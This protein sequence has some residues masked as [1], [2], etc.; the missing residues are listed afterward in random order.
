M[1]WLLF[2]DESGHDHRNTP[3]E[4]HGGFAIHASRLWQFISA[5]RT[6]EQ[7]IFGADLREYGLEL[8][9]SK[10]LKAR[11][12]EWQ[13]QGPRMDEAARRKHAL[14]FLNSGKQR[15]NPRSEEFAAY[16]QGCVAMA[17]G[18]IRLL[19]SHDARL[20]ASIVPRHAKPADAQ[21]DVLRKDIVFLLERFFYFLEGQRQ[22]GLLV[23]DGT[24]K[25]ADRQVVR[26]MERY[27]PNTLTDR[28][29]TQWIVPVPLF[30]E[31]DMAYG[32]Q[33]ADLCIYC[34]TWGWRLRGRMTEPTRPEIE[35]FAEL[36]HRMQWR[37]DGYRAGTVFHTHGFCYVP[38]LYDT[39]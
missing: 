35:P 15:R 18:T 9:G 22:M 29:R 23:M 14:N 37:G 34:L 2:L 6:L 3:Y 36:L 33:V 11:C 28:Q 19:P 24:E 20:F 27:F 8:K 10:L 12:F 21:P 26:R 4:V 30:V 13:A 5:V 31:S 32:V 1:S 16:G 38:D 7:S 25:Q 39:R 17:E